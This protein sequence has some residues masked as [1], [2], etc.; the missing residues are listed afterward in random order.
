MK[1]FPTTT[2]YNPKNPAHNKKAYRDQTPDLLDF[3]IDRLVY[4]GKCCKQVKD[5]ARMDRSHQ[6]ALRRYVVK[7]PTAA[8]AASIADDMK[9]QE[10]YGNGHHH[11]PKRQPCWQPKG[12]I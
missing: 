10:E 8:I 11:R 4:T 5:P 2:V 1:K 3:T 9:F 7:A 12:G 6:L